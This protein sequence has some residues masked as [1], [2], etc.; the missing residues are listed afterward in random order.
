MRGGVGMNTLVK[1]LVIWTTAVGM[2]FCPPAAASDG[3]EDVQ[4][5]AESLRPFAYV[6]NGQ[7]KGY[8]LEIALE[9]MEA[10]GL[11]KDPRK[12]RFLPWSRAYRLL[13]SQPGVCLIAMS[14][15]ASRQKQF[16]FIG[17][18][19][20]SPIGIIAK[21]ENQL[22]ITTVKDFQGI[23]TIG[24]VRD[25]IGAQL[26]R[27]KVAELS[28]IDKVSTAEMAVRM[29]EKN[30][31]TAVSMGLVPFLQT[32]DALGIDSE[33]YALVYFLS[34]SKSGM[35]FNRGTDEQIFKRFETAFDRLQREGRI[36]TI[37]ARYI[38]PVTPADRFE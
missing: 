18:I 2:V 8:M 29:L 34:E 5:I 36:D 24:V 12:I 30:R 25:D 32:C 23:G 21:K 33:R 19:P 4:W 1:A 37:R 20:G 28:N 22:K 6:E 15:T 38:Q 16:R 7:Y 35:A 3:I 13:Q 17:P 26:L 14:M 27:K 9:M 11:S 31:I 10:V